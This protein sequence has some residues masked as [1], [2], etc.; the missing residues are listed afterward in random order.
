MSSRVETF[1]D[2][3]FALDGETPPAFAQSSS[4]ASDFAFQLFHVDAFND[5]ILPSDRG[6]V[7]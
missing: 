4:R 5:R 3:F 6:F 2:V 1:L 7:W